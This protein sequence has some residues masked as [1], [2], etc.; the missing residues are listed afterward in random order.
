[1]IGG[2]LLNVNRFV[3]YQ[4]RGNGD[5]RG[6]SAGIILRGWVRAKT[7]IIGDNG[8]VGNRIYPGW[9]RVVH[10]YGEDRRTSPVTGHIAHSQGTNAARA[11]IRHTAPGEGGAVSGVIACVVRDG[12]GD[13][14]A[15]SRDDTQ[16]SVSQGVSHH[17]ARRGRNAAVG[18]GNAHIGRRPSRGVDD[19]GI[20]VR[21]GVRSF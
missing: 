7:A 10:R 12:F 11:T 19:V 17:A 13:D 15:C 21:G 2:H 6:V 1:M 5:R 18:L 20:I 8:G 4:R 3:H 16:V 14:D 9:Q